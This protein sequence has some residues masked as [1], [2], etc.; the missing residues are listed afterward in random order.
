MAGVA[1]SLENVLVKHI[2]TLEKEKT[3]AKSS[4]EEMVRKEKTGYRSDNTIGLGEVLVKHESKLEMVKQQQ[5]WP[6]YE[7]K[8]QISLRAGEKQEKGN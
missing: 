6:S 8:A 3:A 7:K 1:E 4:W 5:P 2:S